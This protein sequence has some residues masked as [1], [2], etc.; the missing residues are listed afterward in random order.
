M[1]VGSSTQNLTNEQTQI[2]MYQDIQMSCTARA[3]YWR[4]IHQFQSQLTNRYLRPKH[5]QWVPNSSKTMNR[6]K[7]EKLSNKNT[8]VKDTLYMFFLYI[9]SLTSN[10]NESKIVGYKSS[11]EVS[12]KSNGISHIRSYALHHFVY[13][14]FK[15]IPFRCHKVDKYHI[16][17]L[18]RS[19]SNR[20]HQLELG[21]MS[22]V[23]LPQHSKRLSMLSSHNLVGC[24]LGRKRWL[25]CLDM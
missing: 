16:K 7:I 13:N 2:S 20:Q 1:Q 18:Q 23:L 4:P 12:I 11:Q 19:L 10:I 14:H 8:S 3:H 15:S 9:Y 22:S 6:F 25:R 5:S 17:Q 24:I 21:L